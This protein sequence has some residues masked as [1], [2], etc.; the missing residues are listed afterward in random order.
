M[1]IE[2]IRGALARG[3]CAEGQ[4]KKVM[5]PDLCEAQ[6][7]EIMSLFPQEVAALPDNDVDPY[8]AFKADLASVINSHSIE[9]RTDTPDFILAEMIVE[10]LKAFEHATHAKKH[11]GDF[12]D[13]RS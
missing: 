2:N 11:W 6:A 5:D 12:P 1:D 9:N 8:H 13:V 10:H 4:T 3:Y 7:Q